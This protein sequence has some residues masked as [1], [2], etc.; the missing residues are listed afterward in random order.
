MKKQYLSATCVVLDLSCTDILTLSNYVDN[1]I[2]QPKTIHF[3]D[4]F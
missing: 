2:Q 1:G 4:L 3:D